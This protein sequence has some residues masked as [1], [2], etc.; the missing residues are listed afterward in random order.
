MRQS[1]NHTSISSGVNETAGPMEKEIETRKE[2]KRIEMGI[3]ER[4]IV[5]LYYNRR[6]KKTKI[7]TQSNMSYDKCIL[8]LDWMETMDLIKKEIDDD[9]YML[10]SL[11]DKGSELFL[12]KFKDTKN[13]LKVA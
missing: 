9:G 2:L 7:A 8:Y 4:L 6:I 5:L 10:I 1:S 3:V 12:K 13:Y 11:S